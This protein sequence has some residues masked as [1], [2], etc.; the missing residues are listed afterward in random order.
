MRQAGRRR[1]AFRRRG[2]D[3]HFDRL[4]GAVFGSL[5][6]GFGG[7]RKNGDRGFSGDGKRQGVRNRAG[8]GRP[9]EQGRCRVQQG[10]R[11]V[12]A[13]PGGHDRRSGDDLH[14]AGGDAGG[15]GEEPHHH[16]IGRGVDADHRQAVHGHQRALYLR[17]LRAGATAPARRWSSRA[18]T[19]GSS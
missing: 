13:R 11:V 9:P 2:Q 19:P 12:R 7:C 5:R 3:R 1:Q 6:R 8:F 18:A 4:V 17:H 14:R 15:E 16:R 10:A